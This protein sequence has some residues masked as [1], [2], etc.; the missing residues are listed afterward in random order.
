MPQDREMG[1][2][3]KEI[4]KVTITVTVDFSRGVRLRLWLALKLIWLAGWILGWEL[5][6]EEDMHNVPD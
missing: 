2:T 4:P 1:F 5:E 6:I 3:I